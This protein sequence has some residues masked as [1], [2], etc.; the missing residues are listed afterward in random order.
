MLALQTKGRL[1]SLTSSKNIIIYCSPLTAAKT[2]FSNTCLLLPSGVLLT[3]VTYLLQPNFLLILL[4]P[5]PN[6][7]PVL[8]VVEKTCAT[9]PYISDGL[10]T[11]T[12][13]STNETRYIKSN[14]T[15]DTKN[16]IYMIQC[17]RCN[18]NDV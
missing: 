15:C 9:C 12:F 8:S 17:N 1:A 3:F 13:F 6:S 2:F 4:I 10:T 18:L 16:L 14:L 5:I 11:Y 7:L